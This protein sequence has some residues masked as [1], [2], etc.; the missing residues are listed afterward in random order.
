MSCGGE[1]AAYLKEEYNAPKNTA[2]FKYMVSD[3]GK[4]NDNNVLYDRWLI[5]I[6]LKLSCLAI[7]CWK[8]LGNSQL[9]RMLDKSIWVEVHACMHIYI[10]LENIIYLALYYCIYVHGYIWKTLSIEKHYLSLTPLE[11]D[12]TIVIQWTMIHTTLCRLW[13]NTIVYDNVVL[14][15]GLYCYMYHD[16]Q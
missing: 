10:Y 4:K 8:N 14:F 12:E 5:M 6:R 13:Y 9:I 16:S 2:F 15:Y 11:M 3:M 7:V 1:G